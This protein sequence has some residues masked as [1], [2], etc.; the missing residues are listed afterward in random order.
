MRSQ[1]LIVALY[2]LLDPYMT[3]SLHSM[4]FFVMILELI[5]SSLW[6]SSSVSSARQLPSTEAASR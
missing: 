5:L 1:I 2:A 4:I 3:G 6:M